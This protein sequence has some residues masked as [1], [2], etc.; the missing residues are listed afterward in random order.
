MTSPEHLIEYQFD[1]YE[2][3][4]ARSSGNQNETA[5]TIR[6]NC[7]PAIP[8][9][10]S[11]SGK[12]HH[13]VHGCHF[14]TSVLQRHVRECPTPQ[15]YSCGLAKPENSCM[16]FTVEK[17]IGTTDSVSQTSGIRGVCREGRLCVFTQATPSGFV[18]F[19]TLQTP[20]KLCNM[21]ATSNQFSLTC[22]ASKSNF[23]SGLIGLGAGTG[24]QNL[25]GCPSTHIGL[26]FEGDRAL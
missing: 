3:R 13:S 17:S 25:C 16:I 21:S 18:S 11:P 2:I 23:P 7:G 9:R 15:P 14:R 19:R 6:D 4:F 8:V 26:C 20:R 10:D 22:A 5:K 12:Q 24:Q 1:R